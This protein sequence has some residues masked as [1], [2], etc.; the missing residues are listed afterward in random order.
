MSD[1]TILELT[2]YLEKFRLQWAQQH[3]GDLV[4]ILYPGEA[5]ARWLL[6]TY[7]AEHI[8]KV[9]GNYLDERERKRQK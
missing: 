3:P 1:L 4:E 5:V 7:P 2:D 6:A 8:F 9:M